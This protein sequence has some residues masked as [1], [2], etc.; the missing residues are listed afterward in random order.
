VKP[1]RR[2]ALRGAAFIA[3]VS[4]D[5]LAAGIWAGDTGHPRICVWLSA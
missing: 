1:G 3:G 5:G 4:E 2:A